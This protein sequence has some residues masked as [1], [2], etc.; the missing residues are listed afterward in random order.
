MTPDIQP[1]KYFQRFFQWFCHREFYEELVGDLEET[2]IRNIHR[3]GE[4]YARRQYRK[5]VIKLLRPSV[6]KELNFHFLYQLTPDMLQNYVKI[7]LRN[8][9]RDKAS[10]F[11][12][13]MGLAIGLACALFIL[14][15][16]QH[17][18]SVDLGFALQDRIY[19]ITYDERPYREKGRYLVTVAPPLGPTLAE[20]FS[21]V[22]SA[23]RFRLVYDPYFSYQEKQFYE[24]KGYYVEGAFFKLFDFPLAQGNPVTALTEPNTIV[25][26]PSFAEKYFGDENPMGKN[27]TLNGERL[28]K[29]TGVLA[30][31]SK[32]SHLDFDYLLSFKTYQVPF[33]YAL[34]LDSWRWISFPTYILLKEGVNPADFQTKM[35]AY[36]QKNAYTDRPVRATFGLQPLKDI[37]FHSG[38]LISVGRFKR[39]N[40]TYTYDL[41]AMA[42]M[43]L[44]IAG[45]N[46]MNINTARSIKRAKEVGVRKVLGALRSQLLGQ[47]IG[48]AIVITLISLVI[49]V[50]IFEFSRN[51]LF[52]FLQIHFDFN[53]ADYWLLLPL[54]LVITLILGLFSAIY[55]ALVL[56]N[57]QPM[58]VLKGIIKTSSTDLNLRKGLVVVQFAITVGLIACS[59]IVSKQMNYI[60]QKNLGYDH[61]QL[62]HLKMHT[63]DFLQR[64]QVAKDV[65]E[66]NPNVLGITAGD[67][68]DGEYGSVPMTPAGAETGIAMNLLSG[69][70]DYFSTL[71]IEVIQGRDFSAQHPIDTSSGI[72][73]NEAALKVFGWE[74]PLG[75]KLQ[76]SRNINGEIIGIV[77]DFHF[78]SLHDPVKPV[79]TVIPR[80]RMRDI[81]LRLR[82]TDNFT[83]LI[84]SL[85]KDWEQIAPDL[86][87]QFAFFDD[88]LNQQYLA[89]QQFSKLISF[90]SWL[91]I[92][93]AGLGLYGLIAIISTYRVKEIGIRKVLGAS[94]ANISLLL[95]KNFLFLIL[96]AN[97]IALPLAWWAMQNWLQ[98]F[99]YHT[100]IT[101]SL[102]LTALLIS[103]AIGVV[104]LIY[105]VFKSA[106]ENP[107]KA[108]RRE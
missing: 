33:G 92:L 82:P 47:F 21:E 34:T 16:V 19:R 87:F 44:L 17:E 5:E 100:D 46:F 4:Q 11:I 57:F 54:L 42:F 97:M 49:G 64:Y 35:A 40:L 74:A 58:Q 51:A 30:D 20:G 69:Y 3:K 31:N 50:F 13:I 22:E 95:S 98:S 8:L 38:D 99:T 41:L 25:L 52:N 68:M 23:V 6:F 1:P 36:A 48:E 81:I 18:N 43:V 26:T 15:F 39:G 91:A 24:N 94:V 93:I 79:V 72:I 102:W 65:L 29:V 67:I 105:Q 56:S 71:G 84:H 107:I 61:E 37:Y 60:Q 7:A 76:V 106:M 59:L 83:Q 80:R 77:K 73:I 88:D 9:S 90:F 96:L 32:R 78:H 10:A 28:L 2:F 89:D 63:D 85:K 103:L 101:V 70:F 108:L 104:S 86:P 66:R 55:P 12:N 62:V 53:M 45:F 27:L 75:Q 14:L